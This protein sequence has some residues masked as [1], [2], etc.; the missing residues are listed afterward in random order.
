M[1]SWAGLGWEMSAGLGCCAGAGQGDECRAGVMCHTCM[2]GVM[3]H[4][5]MHKP[6]AWHKY[7]IGKNNLRSAKDAHTF[8]SKL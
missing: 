1:I 4:T 3:R 8:F 6:P 5:C 7:R 2:H